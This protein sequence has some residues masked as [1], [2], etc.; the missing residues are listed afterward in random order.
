MVMGVLGEN[1]KTQS[2]LVFYTAS[3]LS[4]FDIYLSF[5]TIPII[6][7]NTDQDTYMES[8]L[9]REEKAHPKPVWSF[10]AIRAKAVEM[11]A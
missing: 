7:S 5:L 8:S 10:L 9:V 4:H 6:Y 3:F 1:N 2:K 11:P